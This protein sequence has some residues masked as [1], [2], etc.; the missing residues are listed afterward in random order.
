MTAEAKLK[1]G[2]DPADRREMILAAAAEIFRERGYAGATTDRLI[3]RSGGSKETVYS[4]FGSKAGL[5]EAVMRRNSAHLVEMGNTLD[6]DRPVEAE[7]IRFGTAYLSV[8]LQPEK[9]GMFRL[10]VAESVRSPELGLVFWRLGPGAV[11]ERL[12]A[13]FA[14]LAERGRLDVED[15][16]WA[17]AQFLAILRG[18]LHIQALLDPAFAFD[19]AAIARQAEAGVKAILGLVG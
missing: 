6:L 13:Y 11:T 16:H 10:A 4:H 14:G 8:I 5:F 12:A 7:L 3:E 9:L 17:A 19:E 1:R 15:P 2:C 18:E